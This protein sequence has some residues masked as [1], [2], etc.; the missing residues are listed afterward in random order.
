MAKLNWGRAASGTRQGAQVPR[1][2]YLTFG[3]AVRLES[4]LATR[5]HTRVTPCAAPQRKSNAPSAARHPV[6]FL[7]KSVPAVHAVLLLLLLGHAL[8]VVRALLLA[9]GLG[10]GRQGAR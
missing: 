9:V 7:S 4:R 8:L 5:P 10:G 3:G 2:L 6:A 1:Q